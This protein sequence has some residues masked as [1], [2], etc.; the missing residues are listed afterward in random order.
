MCELLCCMGLAERCPPLSTLFFLLSLLLRS[1]DQEEIEFMKEQG[2]LD[3]THNRRRDEF[4]MFVEA[5]AK[6]SNL[7]KA[8]GKI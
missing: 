7:L 5:Y 2:F 1:Y 8:P 6:Q 4:V 3:K